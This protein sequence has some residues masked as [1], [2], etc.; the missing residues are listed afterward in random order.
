MLGPRLV[1]RVLTIPIALLAHSARWTGKTQ[2]AGHSTVRVFRRFYRD[3]NALR[4]SNAISSHFAGTKT[5]QQLDLMLRRACPCTISLL[6]Q[7]S[8]GSQKTT[9][10][11]QQK[12][13]IS[14]MESS[15]QPVWRSIVIWMKQLV[16]VGLT[17]HLTAE[18]WLILIPVI[19]VTQ[20]KSVE[21]ISI[22]RTRLSLGL[23]WE[24]EVTSNLIVNAPWKTHRYLERVLA[25]VEAYLD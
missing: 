2:W 7:Y 19:Q 9:I 10:S 8:G 25:T 13:T 22:L 1:I 5:Q 21:S 16:R 15:A 3:N 18:I 11:I 24:Q 12:T 6:G 17:W 23:V 20:L 14:L 4:T